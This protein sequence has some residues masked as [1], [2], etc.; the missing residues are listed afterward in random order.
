M[1]CLQLS[2][3]TAAS[4]ESG[5]RVVGGRG[6]SE[7]QSSR[8]PGRRPES[9]YKQPKKSAAHVDGMPATWPVIGA[10]PL[11]HGLAPPHIVDG[12]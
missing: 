8:E 3:R 5:W 11:G 7:C 12:R 2:E 1:V 4:H 6:R 10:S 9:D